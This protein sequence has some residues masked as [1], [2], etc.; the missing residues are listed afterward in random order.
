MLRRKSVVKAPPLSLIVFVAIALGGCTS[1]QDVLEPSALL[2]PEVSAT[3]IAPQFPLTPQA[4]Q[5][6]TQISALVT[7]ARIQFAPVIGATSA[8]SQPLASRLS[9]QATA[10]GLSLV[11]SENGGA[12]HVLK[13]Y[14]SAISD[15]GQTTVIYVW[16]VLDPAGTRVHR[17]QGQSKAPTRGGDGWS[18][19]E[20]ATMEAIADQT[21]DQLVS[22]LSI[23]QG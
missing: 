17:I 2:D 18:S 6:G 1:S 15:G 19:V 11:T 22:W 10:R 16:D 14:F 23:R 5:S 7:N 12:T 20:T 8:A 4:Q 9:Q 21:L 3:S 13:G